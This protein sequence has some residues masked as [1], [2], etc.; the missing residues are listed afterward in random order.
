MPRGVGVTVV[1]TS[2][3]RRVPNRALRVRQDGRT[4]VPFPSTVDSRTLVVSYICSM[5]RSKGAS[6]VDEDP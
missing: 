2:F 6:S 3:R 1:H 4:M 5:E